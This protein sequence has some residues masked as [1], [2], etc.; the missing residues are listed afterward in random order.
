[1]TVKMHECRHTLGILIKMLSAEAEFSQINSRRGFGDW[2]GGAVN[3][4]QRAVNTWTC[5]VPGGEKINVDT[6]W[7]SQGVQ[8]GGLAGKGMVIRDCLGRS[9]STHLGKVSTVLC[10]E[11]KAW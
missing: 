4:H 2:W 3:E 5:Q 8:F 9:R 10:A 7:W 6:V 1:M 11:A